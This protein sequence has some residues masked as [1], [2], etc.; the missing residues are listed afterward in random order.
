MITSL[1]LKAKLRPHKYKRERYA[2]GN[3][4]KMDLL[5]IIR[6]FEKLSYESYEKKRPNYE[7]TDSYFCLTRQLENCMMR[8]DAINFHV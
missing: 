3:F 2:I 1:G 7:P 4:N 8:S 6:E 5:E